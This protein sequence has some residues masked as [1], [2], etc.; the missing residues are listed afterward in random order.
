MYLWDAINGSSLELVTIEDKG[1]PITSVN[2]APDGQ[3]ITVG[4]NNS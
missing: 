1:N 2:W 3:H 4:L